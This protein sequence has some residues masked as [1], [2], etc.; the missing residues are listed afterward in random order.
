MTKKFHLGWF[1]NFMPPQWVDPF[2]RI[3]S[4]W[5]SAE[6]HV[7]MAQM[8]ERCC[9]DYVMI[10]DTLMVPESFGG[11]TELSLKHALQVPKLDPMLLAATIAQH[12]S[13]LGII[14]TA[15][16]LSAPPFTLARSITTL[17]H[18]TKG[19]FGWNIVTSGEHQAAQN[20]GLAE[21]PARELRYEMA[22]EYVEVVTRLIES[23]DEDAIVMDRESHTF[24]DH[25]RIHEVNF[26]GKHYQS[27]GPLNVPRPPQGRPVYLQAGGSPRGRQFAAEHADSIVTV[28]TGIEAMKAYRDDIRRRA[29]EAG[30]DPDSIKVMF[31][32]IPVLGHSTADAEEKRRLMTSEEEFIIGQLGEISSVTDIDFS[33]FDLDEPLP[34]LT[35]NGEQGTL[36][37]F[38]QSGSGKTLRELV[39]DSTG[40][41]SALRLVG[42]PADVARQMAEAIE[43]VG[44]DG[45]LITTPTQHLSRRYVTEIAEGL[46]PALQDLGV[47]R[48]EYHHQL[49]KDTL[50]EF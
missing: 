17:D 44:G 31:L 30:R 26:E 5:T 49:L 29:A 24:A 4:S 3:N 38:A 12:T 8:L 40:F 37:K 13:R 34:E 11:S 15:S 10:E 43:E 6:F 42:T 25:E 22:D 27:R 47:V 19:R 21:L 46:V 20:L 35:T 9:F 32:A 7:E 41:L 28:A 45:F 50:L 48:T 1:M 39:G 2:D 23:W 33:Q 36:D 14:A 18:L 16:I